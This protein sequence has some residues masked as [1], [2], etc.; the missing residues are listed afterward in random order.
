MEIQYKLNSFS[1]LPLF[2]NGALNQINHINKIAILAPKEVKKDL[3]L[4]ILFGSAAI[5]LQVLYN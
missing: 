4:K 1:R 5:F 3:Q 2:K